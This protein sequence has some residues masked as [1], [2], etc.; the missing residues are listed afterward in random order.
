MHK[1]IF[2]VFNLINYRIY[3]E[4]HILYVI[5][6]QVFKV[7]HR[8]QISSSSIREV[9]TW[10]NWDKKQK[11]H[12]WIMFLKICV[13]LDSN[14]Q[15]KNT[16]FRVFEYWFFFTSW[17]IIGQAKYCTIVMYTSIFFLIPM[18]LCYIVLCNFVNLFCRNH[19][20][21]RICIFQFSQRFCWFYF[22]KKN[23]CVSVD[24]PRIWFILYI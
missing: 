5:L 20:R 19:V 1:I 21:R 11:M 13:V 3:K 14:V 23:R 9:W 22:L 2:Q 7:L 15:S 17:V 4:I 10:F 12:L 8:W 6:E 16:N 18:I 24:Q